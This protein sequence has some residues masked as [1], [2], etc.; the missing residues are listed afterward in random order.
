[1]KL[2][3][4]EAHHLYL[5]PHPDDVVLS[6][7]GLIWQQAQNGESVAVVTV[8]AASPSPSI[9]LSEFARSLHD[10]WEASAHA[11]GN[12][13]DAPAVRREEDRR[14]FERLDPRIHLAHFPLTDCIY[15]VHPVTEEALYAS[16]EGI[17]GEMHPADPALEELAL[18][19][20]LPAE[21]I[22]YCP[23]GVGHHVDHQVVRAIVDGW[24][25]E[26]N[27]VRYY[28]DYPYVTQADALESV[29]GQHEGWIPITTPLD[30]AALDAKIAAVAE[31]AS[32]MSTFWQNREAMAQA[33]RA[34]A[35]EV[36][37]E[38]LW[39]QAGKP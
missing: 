17:F 24:G 31:H 12:F 27:R 6:C 26:A 7:G 5:S 8:F 32:Q 25:L 19:T 1:M 36:G 29:V 34:R 4:P 23:L 14:A 2:R 15:R 38:R 28:E 21:T 11:N 3:W 16:E 20:P 10:R 9:P 35:A 33:L 30:Q 37:G 13:S 18:L 22:V 39:I